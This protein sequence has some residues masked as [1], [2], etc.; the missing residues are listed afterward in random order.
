MAES[1]K[2][3]M[4]EILKGAAEVKL[5]KT[6]LKK[7]STSVS[8]RTKLMGNI[9]NPNLTKLEDTSAALKKAEDQTMRATKAAYKA[10]KA[11]KKSE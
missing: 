1:K 9:K 11:E 2:P 4:S 6:P 10:A 5:A 7:E 8:D 3:N